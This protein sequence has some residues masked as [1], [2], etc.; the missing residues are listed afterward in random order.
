MPNIKNIKDLRNDLL[1]KYENAKSDSEKK[2][3]GTFTAS[4]SAIIRSLKTE[5][6]YNKFK[7]NDKDIHFLEQ[8]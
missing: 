8:E 4:A 1:N 2:D 6:D 5:L 7:D 3:L